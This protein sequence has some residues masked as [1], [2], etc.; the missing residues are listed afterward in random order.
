MEYWDCR[1][2]DDLPQQGMLILSVDVKIR[3][4]VGLMYRQFEKVRWLYNDP[5]FQEKRDA[6]PHSSFEAF[7]RLWVTS[8]T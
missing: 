1:S 5:S 3:Q 8:A 6:F 4:F 7:E 2:W